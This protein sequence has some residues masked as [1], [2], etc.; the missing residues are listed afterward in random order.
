MKYPTYNLIIWIETEIKLRNAQYEILKRRLNDK[1]SF[2]LV[3]K[4][5]DISKSYDLWYLLSGNFH[6][7]ISLYIITSKVGSA[8]F[9]VWFL[10]CWYHFCIHL[11]SCF[12][13]YD[14]SNPWSLI[15]SSPFLLSPF[16]VISSSVFSYFLES[17]CCHFSLDGRIWFL[18]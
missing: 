2:E 8:V 18:L 14:L 17:S 16:S 1:N 9:I 7:K 4:Y 13:C 3:L 12:L 5:F 11:W 6:R 10:Y 15:Y